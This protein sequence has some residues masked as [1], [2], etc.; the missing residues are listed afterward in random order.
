MKKVVFAFIL[1]VIITGSIAGVVAYNYDAKD[2]SFTPTD[3]DW[4]VN[5]VED[6]IKSLKNSTGSAAG[7]SLL[8]T[9][10]NPNQV[11]NPTTI[12]LNLSGYS[13]VLVGGVYDT[14][15]PYTGY[16]IIDVGQSGVLNPCYYNGCPNTRNITVNT[17]GVT[18]DYGSWNGE[19]GCP[20]CSVPTYIFGI[21]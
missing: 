17:S 3:S 8:W 6:A 15:N 12:P 21:K 13:S 4:N 19:G 7:T 14:N 2:V 16:V 11:F 1:G 18:F 9:N 20:E 10:P 5:N